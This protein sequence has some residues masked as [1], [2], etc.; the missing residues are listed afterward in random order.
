MTS[1]VEEVIEQIARM[2]EQE[3]VWS[4]QYE[5]VL[6]DGRMTAQLDEDATLAEIV[7]AIR[8]KRWLNQE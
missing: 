6:L 4:W 7:K 5:G 1:E 8:E 3:Q 2:V